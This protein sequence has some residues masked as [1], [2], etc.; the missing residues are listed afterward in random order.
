MVVNNVLAFK[1][2]SKWKAIFKR[3]EELKKQG[4]DEITAMQ[5]AKKEALEKYI[6]EHC[7]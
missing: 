6:K 7:I 1:K 2:L 4:L 3:A 5:I